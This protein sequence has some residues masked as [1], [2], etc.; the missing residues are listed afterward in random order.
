MCARWLISTVC[1]HASLG[2]S[3]HAGAQCC[4][5]GE[6]GMAPNGSDLAGAPDNEWSWPLR[7]LAGILLMAA[8]LCLPGGGAAAPDT[9]PVYVVEIHEDISH[10][11]TFLIRRALREA[12]AAK[13]SAV[14]LDMETNGGRVDATE[15]IIKLLEHSP[16]KT[17]T[18]VNPKAFSAGAFIASATDRIY[19]AP[20]SVIGAATPVML[21]PGAGAQA[22]PKS[23]E[24]KITSAMRALIRSTAE[25]KGHNPAVFEAMVDAD[26]GLKVGGTQISPK[27][28]LLTLTNEEAAREYGEPP[29]PLLS[30]GTVNDVSALVSTAGLHAAKLVEVKPY[31][32]EVLARWISVISPLLILVGFVA[33]W[34]ELKAPGLGLGTAVAVVAFGLFFLGYFA[35]GLAGW[36]E[37]VLF[38]LGAML[39]ALEIFVIPGFGVAGIAGILLI[40]AALLLAM[41]ER[42]PGQTW[43]DWP[44]WQAALTRLGLGLGGALAVGAW[45]LRW[46]PKTSVF[47]RL[48]LAAT[49]G[50]ADGYTTATAQAELPLGAPGVAETVLRPAGKGRFADR[51]VDVV[52]EGDFIAKGERIKIVAVL[53]S[54]VVVSRWT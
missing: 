42:W 21:A 7:W 17:Y 20:G 24:E 45:L 14:V 13:A 19:M 41:V 44:Q 49:L 50:A 3:G 8:G 54:R 30:A 29:Q 37:V 31:G 9:Q 22:L 46:L 15:E 4:Q 34:A 1:A 10:N 23:Y 38:V 47:Q 11:T 33:I 5:Q 28:K 26:L 35:A 43:P 27:G 36:E 6:T 52:T 32:F 18:Y 53:G 12:E 25:A 2:A 51:L 39:L 40:V 48:E 16:V